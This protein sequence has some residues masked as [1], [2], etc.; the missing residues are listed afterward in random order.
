MKQK[1]N[2]KGGYNPDS[3]PHYVYVVANGTLEVVEHIRGPVFRMVDDPVLI[4]G[5][6]EATACDKG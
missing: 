5:A 3:Y 1:K 4:K 6:R 2:E